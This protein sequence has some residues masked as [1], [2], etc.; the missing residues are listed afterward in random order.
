VRSLPR[1]SFSPLAQAGVAV[2]CVAGGTLL[3]WLLAPALVGA[4]FI[5]YFPA[6]LVAS[7]LGGVGS[8]SIALFLSAATAGYLWL[9]PYNVFDLTKVS[10]TT[11]I[12]FLV[13][14]A[15]VVLGAHLLQ[16]AATM[17]RDSEMRASLIA[18]EMQHRIG[19]KL[20]LVQAVARLSARHA[21]TLEEF[22]EL[23]SERLRALS[24]SQAVVGVDPD[25]PTD[26]A[27]LIRVVLRPFDEQR[28]D[29][30]G[31]LVGV[32]H[33]DRPMLALLV[34]E[35]G[36][37]AVK[38]GALSTSGGRVAIRWSMS[39][40]GVV[41]EWRE[42]GG[43]PVTPPERAGFGTSLASAAFP[44]DRG[45]VSFAYE[46]EGLR[47]TVKLHAARFTVA[48]PAKPARFPVSRGAQLKT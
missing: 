27:A 3:H 22:Q 48:P 13:M 32:E 5:T 11:L 12:V 39:G 36:T 6:V 42:I 23:F 31:P 1:R 26:L 20:A 18:R 15:I 10:V 25:L 9:E 24:E 33:R 46:P 40:P 16:V 28:V 2:A 29:L 38:H 7:V 4:P 41:L 30:G 14:G 34:H 21:T 43:P 19:N 45:A 44:Q 17:A 47:C 35:L 8:G 37:N